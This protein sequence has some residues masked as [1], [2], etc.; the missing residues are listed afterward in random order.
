[1]YGVMKISNNP[2]TLH[3]TNVSTIMLY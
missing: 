3:P 2:Q 1:M